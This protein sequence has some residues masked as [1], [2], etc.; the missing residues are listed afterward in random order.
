MC[1]HFV[2]GF[3]VLQL[4]A[5]SVVFKGR[6]G[7]NGGFRHLAQGVNRTEKAG[8]PRV[9]GG[10]LRVVKGQFATIGRSEA[11]EP[12]ADAT[13]KIAIVEDGIKGLSHADVITTDW[14]VICGEENIFAE[15]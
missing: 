7:V 14:Q 8:P 9:N 4:R 2:D 6:T 3:K 1:I 5:T 13:F 10:I 12:F 11:F 15:V